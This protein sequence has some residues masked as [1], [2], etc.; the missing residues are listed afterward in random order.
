MAI[1]KDIFVGDIGTHF[2]G[3]IQNLVNA[4]PAAILD[5]SGA[6]EKKIVFM[7][8]DEVEKEFDAVFVTDGTDG[9]LEYVTALATDLHVDGG[10]SYYFWVKYP[11]GERRTSEKPFTVYPGRQSQLTA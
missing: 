2:Q 11:G 3:E 1:V 10:W 9:Q 6:T 5:I 7:D 4:E 8:P